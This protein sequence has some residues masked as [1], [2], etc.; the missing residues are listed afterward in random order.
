MVVG[1]FVECWNIFRFFD[2]VSK[3][4]KQIFGTYYIKDI[5][6]PENSEEN[7]CVQHGMAVDKDIRSLKIAMKRPYGLNIK[8]R[9]KFFYEANLTLKK[10]C[11]RHQVFP[12]GHPSKY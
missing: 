11:L 8:L 5:G 6:F 10:L 4:C 1:I 2:T 9:L 7:W 12:G 3:E